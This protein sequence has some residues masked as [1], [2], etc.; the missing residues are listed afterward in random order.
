[1][2]WFKWNKSVWFEC[3]V[4]GKVKEYWYYQNNTK[5]KNPKKIGQTSIT[6]PG[7]KETAVIEFCDSNDEKSYSCKLCKE[8]FD[9]KKELLKHKITHLEK[10]QSQNNF[11]SLNNGVPGKKLHLCN[12]KC[13][14]KSKKSEI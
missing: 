7:K 5:Q 2:D 14:S 1:M 8:I 9:E 6:I 4:K 12:F 11:I 3:K 13:C 10:G